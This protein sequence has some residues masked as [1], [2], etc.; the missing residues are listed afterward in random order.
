MVKH[1]SL[2]FTF[3]FPILQNSQSIMIFVI[4]NRIFTIYFAFTFKK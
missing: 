1:V 4:G 2:Q 3:H